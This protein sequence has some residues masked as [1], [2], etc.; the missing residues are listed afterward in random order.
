[1]LAFVGLIFAFTR[2]SPASP[3]PSE[4]GENVDVHHDIGSCVGEVIGAAAFAAWLWLWESG[5]FFLK[6][7]MFKEK[8]DI[9]LERHRTA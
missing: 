4:V 7:L 9:L 2:P 6:G 5:C 1:M 8:D 3:R